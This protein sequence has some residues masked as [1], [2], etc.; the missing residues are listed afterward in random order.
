SWPLPSVLLPKVSSP[1][2]ERLRE[3]AH[4][5]IHGSSASPLRFSRLRS[6]PRRLLPRAESG[7]TWLPL[8]GHD[9]WY[10]R[11][12]ARVADRLPARLQTQPEPSG[13]LIQRWSTRVIPGLCAN[14]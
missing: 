12:S 3:C 7:D 6:S 1:S 5:P 13:E 11:S 8:R 14:L 4:Q 10:G 2:E 9:R